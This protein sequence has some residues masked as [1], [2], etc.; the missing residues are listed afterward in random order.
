M[1]NSFIHTLPVFIILMAIV[2]CSNDPI[3]IF[4][5][6]GVTFEEQL[7]VDLEIIDNYL[8]DSELDYEIHEP[9]GLRYTI[10]EAGNDTMPTLT[11]PIN[12]D[13]EAAFIP[14]GRVFESNE[15]ITT[16]LDQLI[17][18]FQIGMQLIGEGGI[19]SLYIPSGYAYGNREAGEIPANSILQ[20]NVVLNGVQ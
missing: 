10:Y 15:R 7:Q 20:Y 2:A 11:S 17:E 6:E 4:T 14:D 5:D 13:Y 19:I 12:F 1:K 8:K 16:S 3:Y 18:G 9:S